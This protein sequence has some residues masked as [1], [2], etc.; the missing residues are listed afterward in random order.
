MARAEARI[1]CDIWDDEDFR[2]LTWE[3]Q[4]LYHAILEQKDLSL[5]GV[6]TWTPK[7]FAKLA[8]NA[9]AGATR[10]ALDLL[11]EKRYVLVDDETDELLVRT[12]ITNDRVL[13]NANSIIGM[14]NAFGAIHSQHLRDAVVHGLGEGFMEGLPKRF[15]NGLPRGFHDRVGKPFLKALALAYAGAPPGA[16][17]PPSSLHPP[18]ASGDPGLAGEPPSPPADKPPA[19]RASGPPGEFP[20][21]DHLRAWAGEHVPSI[22]DER[23]LQAETER[24]LDHHRA[25]GS[26]FKDWDAAWRKWMRGAIE[27]GPRRVVNGY[28]QQSPGEAALAE[29]RRLRD[30]GA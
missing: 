18:T 8:A 6:L 5:C 26:L 29:Y 30:V 4:W 14:T 27:Y 16:P 23:R 28:D 15:P 11:R 20:I 3:A 25:K 9:S 12:F 13:D 17:V 19:K 22:C 7:R 24:F 10:K 2:S 21:T 1:K